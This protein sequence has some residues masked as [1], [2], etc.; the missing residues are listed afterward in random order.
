MELIITFLES[1]LLSALVSAVVS[2]LIAIIG[3]RLSYKLSVSETQK[4]M[5]YFKS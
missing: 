3:M 4:A 2:G 1:N 5:E